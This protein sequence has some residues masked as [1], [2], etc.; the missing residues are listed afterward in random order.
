MF[1]RKKPTPEKITYATIDAELRAL[2]G[3]A[4][5]ARISHHALIEMLESSESAIRAK[6]AVSYSVAPRM[7]S[8]NI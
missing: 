4:E 5:K 3:K 1:F 2:I 6:L 7:H 8:G